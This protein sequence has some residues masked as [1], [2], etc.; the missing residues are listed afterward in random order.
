MVSDCDYPVAPPTPQGKKSKMHRETELTCSVYPVNIP[1]STI[2]CI[3][4]DLFQLLYFISL[5]NTILIISLMFCITFMTI[6][7]WQE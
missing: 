5:L 6:L 7:F 4:V 1:H 2:L 3:V